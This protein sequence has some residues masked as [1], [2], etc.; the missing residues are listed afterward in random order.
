MRQTAVKRKA[1]TFVV[2]FILSSIP[3]FNDGSLAY[4]FFHSTFFLDFSVNEEYIKFHQWTTVYK[5][6]SRWKRKKLFK[7]LK[8][9]PTAQIMW[10]ITPTT[11]NTIKK[12]HQVELMCVNLCIGFWK[13]GITKVQ[14]WFPLCFYRCWIFFFILIFWQYKNKMKF[15]IKY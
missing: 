9:F 3:F 15:I 10:F 12:Q 5:A 2:F 13:N 1:I 11:R 7:I 4:G 14:T 6:Q 8:T